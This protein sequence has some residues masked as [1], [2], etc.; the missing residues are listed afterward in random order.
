MTVRLKLMA[1][2]Y[3]INEGRPQRMMLK[4]HADDYV[5]DT[6]SDADAGADPDSIRNGVTMFILF[7]VLNIVI[8]S[9]D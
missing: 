6:D 7:A 9:M 2:I 5:G 3:L 1:V 8:V 4:D